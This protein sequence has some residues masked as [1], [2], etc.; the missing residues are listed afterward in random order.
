MANGP[1]RLPTERMA[2]GRDEAAESLGLPDQASKMP[3][4]LVLLAAIV[5][6]TATML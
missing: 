6:V 1:S 5:S 3:F 4:D 2:F